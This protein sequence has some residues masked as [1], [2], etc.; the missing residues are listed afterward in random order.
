MI[1]GICGFQSSGKDTAAEYL[2]NN[3]N[4][5]RFSFATVLKDVVAIMFGWPRDRLEG[6]TLEDRLWREQVDEWWANALHMP[7]F[8]PRF[9]LQ[10]IAT[11]LFRNHFHQD[12]WLKI[13]EN[14]LRQLDTDNTNVVIS[15]CRFPNEIA[16]I[17]QCG[18]KIIHIYRHAKPDWVSE[19][20][21]GNDRV[22]EIKELHVSEISWLR[23]PCDATIL[24]DS[25]R[26]NLNLKIEELLLKL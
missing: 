4:F 11:D 9:A 21:A 22:E 5:I 20:E 16:M 3:H 19:Y 18:G 12:I 25:T 8:T 1:L 26:E 7:H 23:S 13:V 10:Y 17:Q 15:D 14:K 6:I 24:N 2:I